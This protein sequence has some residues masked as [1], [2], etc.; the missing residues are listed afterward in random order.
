VSL[1]VLDPILTSLCSSDSPPSCQIPGWQIMATHW[2]RASEASSDRQFG[3]SERMAHFKMLSV[4][5]AWSVELWEPRYNTLKTLIETPTGTVGLERDLIL[6]LRS[7]I[8]GAFGRLVTSDMI[9]FEERLERERSVDV[10]SKLLISVLLDIKVASRLCQ[11][12][13]ATLLESLE[14]MVGFAL[15]LDPNRI[16]SSQSSSQS[17]TVGHT[18]P[19]I[20][21]SHRRRPSSNT[22]PMA[23]PSPVTVKVP[24]DCIIDV[25]VNFITSQENMLSYNHL[26][27]TIP[28]LC[29]VLAYYNA[30]IP[31]PSASVDSQSHP[32]S[33]YYKHVV[34]ALSR[35][36]SGPYSAS[37]RLI[38][39]KCLSPIISHKRDVPKAIQIS[40]GAFRILRVFIRHA[41]RE[42][43]PFSPESQRSTQVEFMDEIDLDPGV[44]SFEPSQYGRASREALK[45]WIGTKLHSSMCEP[46]LEEAVGIINDVLNVYDASELQALQ[47]D[48]SVAL[49]ESLLEI[50]KYIKQFR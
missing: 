5:C 25:Y 6:T 34:E 35:L 37:V 50:V 28:L 19:R 31:V 27:T 13:I 14:G 3:T 16:Y 11:A 17:P 39:K 45:A 41:L 26:E 29:R 18:P 20:S 1:T 4:P 33:P 2:K 43:L 40:T 38:V 42:R 36:L 47:S 44:H 7:W 10:L 12:D 32:T 48:E 21:L 24:L 22:V 15:A 30:P 23:S 8:E 46:V 49:G 9:P